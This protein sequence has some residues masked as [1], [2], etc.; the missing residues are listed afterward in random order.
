MPIVETLRNKYKDQ[1][2]K[3]SLIADEILKIQ[4]KKFEVDSE[5][6]NV[7][8]TLFLYF[9]NKPLF[10]NLEMVNN[11]SL[12]KGILLIGN[13]GSGKTILMESFQKMKF[14]NNCFRTDYCSDLPDDYKL[15]RQDLL[16]KTTSYYKS[17]GTF[18]NVYYDDLGDEEIVNDYGSY[19][20]VMDK[21]IVRRNRMW[22]FKNVKSHL[23]TNLP[24]SEIKKRYGDRVY[25]RLIQQSNII[26]L[27]ADEKSKNRRLPDKDKG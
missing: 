24:L 4:G 25:G 10:E 19:V 15:K 20:E 6:E 2:E 5:N 16:K 3:L 17:D 23:S 14:I 12:K 11:F 27:G 21:I 8:Y 18:N 13:T 1:L 22:V 9:N 26:Y 7:I